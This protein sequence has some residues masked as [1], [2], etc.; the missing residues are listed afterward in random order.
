MGGVLA[1]AAMLAALAAGAPLLSAQKKNDSNPP[2]KAGT[3]TPADAWDTFSVDVSVRTTQVDKTGAAK[4]KAEELRY[5]LQREQTPGGWKT[6][7]TMGDRAQPVAR[8]FDGDRP[9]SINQDLLPARME[10]DEDGTPVRFYNARGAR[11]DLDGLKRQSVG[12]AAADNLP[13]LLP[14]TT[15]RQ[16]VTGREWLD[17]F[18]VPKEKKDQRKR[19]LELKLGRKRGDLRGLDRFV[20]ASAN[21]QQEVLVDSE[22]G[23]PVEINLAKDGTLINHTTM[24]YE[25]RPDGSLVRR[26]V[27][28]EQL[29]ERSKQAT[30]GDAERKDK[31]KD[32]QKHLAPDAG[33][34]LV[35]E[36]EFANLRLE[37]KGGAR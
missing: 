19:A 4:S 14:S 12:M 30:D 36:I 13:E 5:R 24:T 3:G 27:R 11:I 16:R 37:R 20:L 25:P 29:I 33:D 6:T 1:A 22:A 10:D 26:A 7:V 35:S 32:E 31:Q 17:A 28:S 34:R 8:S 21:G 15:P 18:V 23:V 9:I 2:D